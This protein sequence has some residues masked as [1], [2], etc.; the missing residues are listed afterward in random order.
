MDWEVSHVH[1]ACSDHLRR[2]QSRFRN[3]FVGRRYFD[4]MAR[5]YSASRVV[6]NRSIRNDVNMRV[7]EAVACGSLLMTNDL[8]DNGQEELFRDGVHLATYREAE[9]LIEKVEYYLAR[10][11]V[12]ERIAAAGRAEVL[13]RHTYRHR[14]ERLLEE[15]E[16]K[17][18]AKSSRDRKKSSLQRGKPL[19]S[20]LLL[21][22][23]L[24]PLR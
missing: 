22:F 1:S 12:R 14:M 23:P 4:E 16:K 19:R 15:V 3:T 18:P 2:L 6:F 24:P 9:E 5:T 17:I 8:R 13:A 21:L 10:E 11:A 7:F 20:L